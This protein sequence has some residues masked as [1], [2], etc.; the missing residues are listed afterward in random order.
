MISDKLLERL[1]DFRRA[2]D[3]EQFHTA[4]NLASSIVI[5]ASELLEKYQWG[6]DAEIATI[7]TERK[8]EI[9]DEIADIAILLS[10]L[11]HD[12]SLDFEGIVS[13]KLEKNQEKYPVEK[14]KGNS[15]KYDRL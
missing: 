15:L 9:A 11:A 4:R 6:T 8:E 14:S 7:N 3:W 10:Y 5:E 1:L 13:A 12:L 2:R